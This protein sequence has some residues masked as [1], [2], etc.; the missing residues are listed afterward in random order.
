MNMCTNEW[1]TVKETRNRWYIKKQE[2][3]EEEKVPDY[4]NTKIWS[5][6][7]QYVISRT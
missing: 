2:K 4:P 3:T 5:S 7:C 1:K 6:K